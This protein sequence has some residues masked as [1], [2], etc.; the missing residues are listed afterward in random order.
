MV[1]TDI[2]GC[3]QVVDDGVTGRLVPVG[4]GAALA[5]AVV[6]LAGDVDRRVAMG[7]AGRAKAAREFDQQHSIDVTLGLYRQLLEG[8]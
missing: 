6:S 1:A 3:R 7:A 5:E 2:R 4:D 8:G